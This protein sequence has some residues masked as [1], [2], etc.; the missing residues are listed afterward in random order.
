MGTGR[1]YATLEI[2]AGIA[3]WL[4]GFLAPPFYL[5]AR[6]HVPHATNVVPAGV[7]FASAC[8]LAGFMIALLYSAALFGL[9]VVR[10]FRAATWASLA[11]CLSFISAILVI[12]HFNLVFAVAALVWLVWGGAFWAVQSLMRTR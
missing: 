9:G 10:G 4:L 12:F 7:L 8:V 5:W 2:T 6:Q 11:S 3:P 1:I